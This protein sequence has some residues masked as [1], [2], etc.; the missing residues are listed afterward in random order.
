MARLLGI[1]G[2]NVLF[3]AI[4]GGLTAAAIVPFAAALG[5]VVGVVIGL[6]TSPV[7]VFSVRRKTLSVSL[8]LIYSATTVVSLLAVP[9]R[10]P[11][12]VMILAMLTLGLTSIC[13]W[14]LLPSPPSRSK[15]GRVVC[16][17]CG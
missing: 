4:L 13:V 6:V 2:I 8:P 14:L 11:A 15:D 3:G 12:F 17:H 7:V 10:L 1:V 16:K 9:T 5:P